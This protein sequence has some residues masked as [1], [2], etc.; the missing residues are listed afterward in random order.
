TTHSALVSG[1]CGA[2]P[3]GS[4][5]PLPER[6]HPGTCAHVR[7]AHRGHIVGRAHEPRKV[8]RREHTAQAS[9]G[10]HDCPVPHITC[11]QGVPR[12][13]PGRLHRSRTV[14]TIG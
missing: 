14:R 13:R 6:F 11:G 3:G 2:C 12:G 9:D 8:V 5:P 10:V 7:D 1:P 4:G